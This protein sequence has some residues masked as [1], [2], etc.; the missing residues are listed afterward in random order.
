MQALN[1]IGAY[2]SNWNL[3]SNVE[4]FA[5]FTAKFQLNFVVLISNFAKIAWITSFAASPST[6]FS[7]ALATAVS[8]VVSNKE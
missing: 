1:L 5:M 6:Y 7:T 4:S 8:R 3:K 2:L